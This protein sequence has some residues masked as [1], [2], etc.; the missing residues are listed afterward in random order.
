MK[1]IQFLCIATEAV[2][3]GCFHPPREEWTNLKEFIQTA[4]EASERFERALK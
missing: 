3:A 1:F 2:C 4:I